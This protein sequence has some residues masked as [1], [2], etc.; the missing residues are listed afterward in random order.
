M[1]TEPSVRES[2]N[3]KDHWAS[4]T[5]TNKIIIKEILWELPNVIQRH[6]LSNCC[7]KDG[8]DRFA[9]WGFSIINLLCTKAQYYKGQQSNNTID[10]PVYIFILLN[11]TVANTFTCEETEV[12]SF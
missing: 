5:I 1:L 12:R 8:A 11:I 10:I 7:W 3:I 4:F 9:S 6:K 2:S